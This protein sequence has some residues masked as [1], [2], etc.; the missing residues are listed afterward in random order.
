[1]DLNYD[2]TINPVEIEADAEMTPELIYQ[3]FA[4]SNEYKFYWYKKER[5]WF[6]YTFIVQN[7]KKVYG[8]R[9]QP[10]D[11]RVLDTIEEGH[12]TRTFMKYGQKVNI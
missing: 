9:F 5:F 2:H 3:A 11:H 12:G 7:I 1:M 6:Y 4:L 8:A 10:Y